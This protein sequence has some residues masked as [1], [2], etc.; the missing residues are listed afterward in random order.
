MKMKKQFFLSQ[1]P[2]KREKAGIGRDDFVAVTPQVELE[3]THI[4]IGY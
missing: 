3:G 2:G 4:H 1:Y